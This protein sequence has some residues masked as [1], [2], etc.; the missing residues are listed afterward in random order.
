MAL[1]GLLSQIDL[2]TLL[3]T[4]RMEEQ[5]GVLYLTQNQEKVNLYVSKEGVR[6]LPPNKGDYTDLIEVLFRN[7]FIKR[8]ELEEYKKKQK[9]TGT[10]FG[11]MLIEDGLL[12]DEDMETIMALFFSEKIFEC[13]DWTEG[14]FRFE[15]TAPLKELEFFD[16]EGGGLFITFDISF[17]SIELARQRDEWSKMRE[18]LPSDECIF[19][20]DEDKMASRPYEKEEFSKENRKL[21]HLLDGKKNIAQLREHSGLS[22]FATYTALYDLYTQGVIKLLDVTYLLEEAEKFYQDDRILE[23]NQRYNAAI[24]I[25][26]NNMKLRLSFA[27]RCMETGNLEGAAE[28]FV[29]VAPL[30]AREG[31]EKEAHKSFKKALELCPNNLEFSRQYFLFLLQHGESDEILQERGKKTGLGF[32][33][34]KNYSKA[35]EIYEALRKKNP[36]DLHSR[37]QLVEI[38]QRLR[39]RPSLPKVYEELADIY[40][41]QANYEGAYNSYKALH[42][43]T[44]SRGDI[45]QKMKGLEQFITLTSKASKRKFL[46]VATYLF[47]LSGLAY[48][49]YSFIDYKYRQPQ[50]PQGVLLGKKVDTLKRSVAKLAGLA[51]TQKK[52]FLPLLQKLE[53]DKLALTKILE[54]LNLYALQ[55]SGLRRMIERG[56]TLLD[57]VDSLRKNII[58]SLKKENEN[59]AGQ[60]LVLEEEKRIEDALDLYEKILSSPYN[61]PQIPPRIKGKIA[62]LSEELSRV[63]EKVQKIRQILQEGRF[64]EALS[65]SLKFFR[66]HGNTRTA[67]NFGLPLYMAAYPP[68]SSISF[69][70]TSKTQ[71][72]PSLFLYVPEGQYRFK[73]SHPGYRPF[74]LIFKAKIS[75]KGLEVSPLFNSYN[76]PPQRLVEAF[77]KGRL[78]LSLEKEPLWKKTI[79]GAQKFFFGQEGENLYVVANIKGSNYRDLSN[80]L[81]YDLA[82]GR[83]KADYAVQ[84]ISCGGVIGTWKREPR[85]FLASGKYLYCLQMKEEKKLQL[86]WT[87][88]FRKAIEKISNT[89]SDRGYFALVD[90]SGSLYIIHPEDGRE[91]RRFPTFSPFSGSPVISGGDIYFACKDGRVY[92]Q[93]IEGGEFWQKDLSNILTAPLVF[94]NDF[95]CIGTEEGKVFA[96]NP[97]R[98]IELWVFSEPEKDGKILGNLLWGEEV[99]LY[100]AT[101]SRHSLYGLKRDNGEKIW[102]KDLQEEISFW[103]KGDTHLFLAQKRSL[104]IYSLSPN[105]KPSLYW[106]STLNGLLTGPPLP[107]FVKRTKQTIFMVGTDNGTIYCFEQ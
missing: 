62:Y 55:D 70:S 80:I 102:Q 42:K 100:K 91:L 18:L 72:S 31:K 29:A 33:E 58:L 2:G 79:E 16:P 64:Q 73:I 98:D 54:K 65:E 92:G 13:F 49:V 40:L 87:R 82:T 8:D 21:L 51:G 30:L 101:S 41:A 44:P 43:L 94:E 61:F 26:P 1:E 60:A 68:G 7:R 53:K 27:R 89:I 88:I 24:K 3:Q 66:S 57:Q 104:V 59:L 81:V 23:G 46:W 45:Q 75:S 37:K 5:E 12:K 15:N 107:F 6:Y 103:S 67:K 28:Q 85:F 11:E 77:L 76:L 69:E 84:G 96:H 17:L 9:R 95:L 36:G 90:E 93:K 106:K 99:I 86:L 48:M 25:N 52:D 14:N 47:I 83:Q 20:I 4:L 39:Q 56:I 19:V 78:D 50:H 35:Q 22:K 10:P 105:Q 38:Y 74:E 97:I 34:E 63:K 32:M 71:K